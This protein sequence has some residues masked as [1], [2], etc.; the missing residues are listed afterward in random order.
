M[1]P[2][3]CYHPP[4][5]PCCSVF[6]SDYTIPHTAHFMILYLSPKHSLP[7]TFRFFA[8]HSSSLIV[9]PHTLPLITSEPWPFSLAFYT[10]PLNTLHLF[11]PHILHRSSS[12]ISV[13]HFFL[14]NTSHL[15]LQL[16]TH[17]SLS[18]L[19]TIHYPSPHHPSPPITCIHLSPFI[20]QHS[21]PHHS[22]VLITHPLHHHPTPPFT[23]HQASKQAS[24]AASMNV[25]NE[26]TPPFPSSPSKS[27][28]EPSW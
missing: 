27:L 1:T 2:E 21:I 18:F 3:L 19:T 20:T 12:F 28:I 9:T 25:T 17:Y 4:I 11:P 16:Q 26:Q 14:L 7:T 10:A 5:L 13:F 24:K 15:T 8:F 23:T 6:T 22:L